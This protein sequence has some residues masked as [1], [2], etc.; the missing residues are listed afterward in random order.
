VLWAAEHGGAGEAVARY[1]PDTEVG[2]R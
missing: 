1:A 2:T